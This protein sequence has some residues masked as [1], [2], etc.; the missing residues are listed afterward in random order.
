MNEEACPE[1]KLQHV[2]RSATDEPIPLFQ[3]RVDCLREAGR[4]LC[5]DFEGKFLNCIYNANYSAAALVNLLAES[6]SCFRDETS[7]Q[8][9]RVRLYKRAQIL[10][11]DLWACFNGESFGEFH[12]IDKITMFAGMG[13]APMFYN[14]ISDQCLDYRIPQILHQLGC[15]VYSPPLTSH[16]RDL[17][18]LPHGSTWEVE[19]RATSIW[20]VEL[21]RREIELRHPGSQMRTKRQGSVDKSN[22][23]SPEDDPARKCSTQKHFK[24]KSVQEHKTSNVNAVLIDFFLYDTMKEIEA[25]RQESIPHH[26][27]R[28]IWY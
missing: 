21:I 20:C 11:A 9:R 28:S 25:E 3:E 7:F 8:G 2:F 16:I 18:P 15:L 1:E 13:L 12:D 27:T 14:S 10:V 22:T 26:R 17:K 19:L 4:V 23:L 24:Q 5:K 6:F